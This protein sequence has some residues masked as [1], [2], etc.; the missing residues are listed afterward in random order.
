MF[1]HTGGGAVPAPFTP[2]A[3]LEGWDVEP[4]LMV[5]VAWLAIAYLV[6]WKRSR[7]LPGPPLPRWR[8]LAFLGGLG[9]LLIATDGPF[10]RYGD[11]NMAVHMGQHMVLLYLVAPVL[12][13][14]A[15]LTVLRNGLHPRVR[16]RW[17]DPVVES[18]MLRALS[19][20]MLVA[21]CY[22][23]VLYATHFTGWYNAALGNP[24]IHD[25]EHVAYLVAGFA[26][27]TVLVGHDGVVVPR[28][29]ARR[30]AVV[31]AM[32]VPMTVLAVI[33]IVAPNPLYPAYVDEPAPWGGRAAAL[34]AQRVAGGVMWLPSVFV[35][36]G[37]LAWLSVAWYRTDEATRADEPI[38]DAEGASESV[39]D[40]REGAGR[41]EFVREPQQGRFVTPGGREVDGPGQPV[42][43]EGS[44]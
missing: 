3:L 20:P 8:P 26:L 22:L 39:V 9:L 30:I 44:R 41:F 7:A 42:G 23:G 32:I 27:W 19:D 14:G 31:F 38:A 25:A 18:R 1:A 37:L 34:A 2:G 11:V 4:L 33:F 29:A 24:A 40:H 6:C 21:A 13:A 10:D 43:A 12:V 36:L 5:G 15:P 35:T 17:V 28:S 16:K